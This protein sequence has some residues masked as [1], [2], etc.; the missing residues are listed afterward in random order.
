M[1]KKRHREQLLDELKQLLTSASSTDKERK[2]T[3]ALAGFLEFSELEK[4]IADCWNLANNKEQ[5]IAEAIWAGARCCNDQP[6][7]LLGPM[8]QFLAGLS[9]ERVSEFEESPKIRISD[10]L[11]FALPRGICNR[12]INYFISLYGVCRSLNWPIVIMLEHIDV[13]VAIELVVRFSAKENRTFFS[14]HLPDSWDPTH[15]AGHRLSNQSMDQLKKLWSSLRTDGQVKYHAFRIWVNNAQQE[16]I[17]ILKE[18]PLDS[19]LY[20]MSIRKRAQLGDMSVVQQLVLLLSTDIHMFDVAHNVYCREILGVAD[21]YL[22]SIKNKIPNET[23]DY[24]DNVTYYLSRFLTSIPARDSETLLE[25]YWRHLR[26][27]PKFV[28]AALYIGTEKSLRLADSSINGCPDKIPIFKGLN[29]TFGFFETG[30]REFLT[31]QHLDRLAPYLD[32]YDED[33]LWRLADL[34]QRLGVPEWNK[35]QISNRLTGK[36]QAHFY[37]LMKIYFENWT[38]LL[39]VHI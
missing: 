30:R 23:S 1:Q 33:I 31:K 19:S 38:N 27:I 22:D 39:L 26:C 10:E 35:E 7:M 16:Q 14:M 32:R 11:S 37:L 6:D 8:M 12:V 17:D 36:W 34:S 21:K 15:P 4:E 29:S 28:Q 18:I 2:G 24:S 13:P 20:R 25:K 5:V 9:D 3:L